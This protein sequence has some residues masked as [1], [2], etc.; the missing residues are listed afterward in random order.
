MSKFGKRKESTFQTEIKWSV[1]NFNRINETDFEYDKFEDGVF[2]SRGYDMEIIGYKRLICVELKH[3][4]TSV[5][6]LN[7]KALFSNGREKEIHKLLKRES[8]GF[9]AHVLVCHY[10]KEKKIN[11]A[12]LFTPFK[13]FY[14][15][16]EFGSIKISEIEKCEFGIKIDRIKDERMNRYVW[17]LSEII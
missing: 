5:S 13:A 16:K 10:H 17:D 2:H 11:D 6:T 1:D 12:Y 4:K 15:L 3:S 8:Q 9:E 7:F 14:I